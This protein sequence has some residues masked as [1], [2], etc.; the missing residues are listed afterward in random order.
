MCRYHQTSPE[1]HFTKGRI[2]SLATPNGRISLSE[3]RLI[4]TS[5]DGERNERTLAS[6]EEY[7]AALRDQFGVVMTT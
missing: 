1:S 2:C 5:N 6:E 7:A 4:T 3:M